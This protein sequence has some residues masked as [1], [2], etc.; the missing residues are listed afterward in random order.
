MVSTRFELFVAL[1]AGEEEKGGDGDEEEGERRATGVGL[2]GRRCRLRG[3]GVR[4]GKGGGEEI[5]GTWLN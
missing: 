3:E 5:V 4:P 2:V 1:G